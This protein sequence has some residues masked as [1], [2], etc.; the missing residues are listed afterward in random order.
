MNIFWKPIPFIKLWW[1]LIQTT[2]TIIFK[3]DPS[4]AG[5]SKNLLPNSKSHKP[6]QPKEDIRQITMIIILASLAGLFIMVILMV[7]II[8]MRKC[9]RLTTNNS[10]FADFEI[11]YRENNQYL[12]L[13]IIL[14]KHFS[15]QIE[16]LDIKI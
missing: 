11:Y 9:D 6:E 4:G 8:T 12:P 14:A 1:I 13:I 5:Q 2:F 7:L 16:K 15:T 10:E 3:S